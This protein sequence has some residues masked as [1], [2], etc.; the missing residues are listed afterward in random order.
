MLWDV[1]DY[2]EESPR[3][4]FLSKLPLEIAIVVLRLLDPKSLLAAVLVCWK[5]AHLCRSDAILRQRVRRQLRWEMRERINPRSSQRAVLR[6][7]QG[8][9]W[10]FAQRNSRVIVQSPLGQDH[11]MRSYHFWLAP[12]LQV[13]LRGL[14]TTLPRQLRY[15]VSSGKLVHRTASGSRMRL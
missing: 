11:S 3:I 4:D 6:E 2:A 14:C 13:R 12:K 9:Y 8:E 10:P 5:W 7:V 1:G 15:K